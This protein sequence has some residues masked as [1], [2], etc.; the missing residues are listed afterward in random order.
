M[1]FTWSEEQQTAFEQARAFAHRDLNDNSGDDTVAPAWRPH[2]WE[3]C[4]RFGLLGLGVPARWG[5]VEWDVRS[6]IRILEGIGEGCR[7]NGLLLAVGAQLWS[8]TRPLLAFGSDAQKDAWLPRLCGGEAV[9]AFALTEAHGGSDALHL[10]TVAEPCGSGFRL[11]GGKAFITNAP[12]ADLFLLLARRR[13]AEGWFALTA[14]LVP[15]ATPGL[16]I[17]PPLHKMGLATSPMADLF[18][19]AVEVGPEAVLGEVGGGASVL[20]HTLEW[21][22]GCLLAP[23]LGT[24][25]R[26]LQ[27]SIDFTRQRQQFGRPII[28]FEAVAHQVAE[29]SVRRDLSRLQA[30]HFAW[31]KDHGRSSPAAASQVKL[32]LSENLRWVAERA[33]HLHGALGYTRAFEFERCW[34]DAMASSL[35][36]GTT[37]IQKNLI[38]EGLYR[39]PATVGDQGARP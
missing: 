18:L 2:L 15:R 35:Y 28:E 7:D 20:Q 26:L 8:V 12:C 24:M 1:D 13:G 39:Q 16:S 23:A 32:V 19:D 36:S 14:F 38:A 34:R 3:R 37:E 22:R 9:A 25:T 10:R 31:L 17:G 4:A 21:E 27:S 6:A 33:M 11:Q 29:M 5:G 30:Y